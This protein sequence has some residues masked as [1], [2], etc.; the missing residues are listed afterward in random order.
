MMLTG[1]RT[2]DCHAL[3]PFQDFVQLLMLWK[4]TTY[5]RKWRAMANRGSDFK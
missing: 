2:Q 3:P 5:T 1:L 4:R